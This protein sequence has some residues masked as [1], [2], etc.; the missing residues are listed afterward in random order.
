M[1]QETAVDWLVERINHAKI[2]KKLTTQRLYE[3]KKIAKQIEK[4]QI[5]EAYKRE[6]PY[7]KHAGCTDEMIDKSSIKYYNKTYGK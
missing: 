2:E 1:S 7:M 4:D 5:I 3:L 6:S